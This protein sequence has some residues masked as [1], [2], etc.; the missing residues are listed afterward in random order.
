MKNKTWILSNKNLVNALPNHKKWNKFSAYS[1]FDIEQKG[2]SDFNS[3]SIGHVIPRNEIYEIYKNYDPKELIYHLYKKYGKQFIHK[4]KGNFTIVIIDG[5][6]FHIFSDRFG[7]KKFF[8]WHD[9]KDF[10]ISDDLKSITSNLTARPSAENMAIYALTY[11]FVGGKTI[12]ENINYNKPAEVISF[13]NGKLSFNQ[14]WSAGELLNLERKQVSIE[15]ISETLTQ[16]VEQSLGYINSDQVSLSLTGGADTRNLL[17]VFL[18]LGI[19]PHLYT[20]GNPKSDDCVKA[21][22]VAK[23]LNI[24]HIIHDIKMTPELFLEYAKYIALSGQGLASI[25]RAHRIISVQKERDF[26]RNMFLGTLGGEFIKGVSEDDYIVPSI[27]Y[28]NWHQESL[29]DIIISSKLYEK[30]L[31]PENIKIAEVTNFLN[32]ESYF[33]GSPTNRKFHS[34]S[35]ITASLHDAQDLNLYETAMENVFTPFLDIDYLEK[36]FTSR[37]TFNNKEVIKNKYLRRI[38]NPVYGSKFLDITYSP[39]LD[40]E[41]SGDHIPREVLLN[42]YYASITKAIRKK[43]RPNYPPNFPLSKWMYDFALKELPRCNDYEILKK[44]FD[45]NKLKSDLSGKEYVPKESFWLRFTNPIMMRYIIDEFG[46]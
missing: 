35:H 19:K 22:A 4:V 24:E 7:I 32:S 20:Y 39:L 27:V 30:S 13:E 34:L 14:Y 5:D 23:G 37:F 42:K 15:E 26:A 33:N 41:Y 12:F 8:Y 40:F 9:G 28:E 31:F 21:A 2:E 17:S 25:H 29:S 18:K 36:L 44:T 1:N 46:I 10:I 11:H 43:V 16:S 45:I 3:F 38:E 6:N